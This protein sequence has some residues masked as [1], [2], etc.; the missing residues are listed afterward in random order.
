VSEHHPTRAVLLEAGAQ[1]A[2]S[3]G[4]HNLS[5][6]NVVKTAGLAKGTFYVH[7]PDRTAFLVALHR[8]FHDRVWDRV[9]Q[10]TAGVSPGP[11]RLQRAAIAYLD[12]CRDDASTRSILFDAQSEP[13]IR[14]EVQERNATATA[15]IAADLRSMSV[16]NPNH[17]ARL[18]IAMV[19]DVAL[20]E[21]DARRT[22][23]AL[24][25]AFLEFLPP[26]GGN[27]I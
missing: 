22:L 11:V 25:K 15:T 12:A 18:V 16:P 26:S 3:E 8:C 23:P 21:R 13:A 7:F 19:V 10:A 14:R 1:L 24:R 6:N 9:E 20:A 5:I 4:L 27:I 17:A 2:A